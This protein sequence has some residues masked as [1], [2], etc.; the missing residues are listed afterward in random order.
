MMRF[1]APSVTSF[2]YEIHTKSWYGILTK[3]WY[4][5]SAVRRS[6]P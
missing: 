2:W 5:T 6:E 3:F 1:A 4:E